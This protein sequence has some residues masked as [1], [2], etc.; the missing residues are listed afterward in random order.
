MMSARARF[1]QARSVESW[2]VHPGTR[3]ELV[4]V[5]APGRR[6]YMAF[7]DGVILRVSKCARFYV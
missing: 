3:A 7:A 2:L 4:S 5:A 1:G 6:V